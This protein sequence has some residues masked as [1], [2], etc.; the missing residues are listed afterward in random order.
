MHERRTRQVPIANL[1]IDEGPRPLDQE[2]V[3]ALA[4]S[5]ATFGLHTPI[6]ADVTAG[7]DGFVSP[8]PDKVLYRIITGRHR[9][10]AAKQLGWSTIET[11]SFVENEFFTKLMDEE[12][13]FNEADYDVA[14]EMWAIAENLHRAE[15]NALQ[16]A[17]QI[18]RWIELEE[19]WRASSKVQS[20]RVAPIESKREDGRGHRPEGGINAASRELGIERTEAQRSVKIAGL[21]DEAKIAAR[22]AGFD[23]NQK[24][25]LGA[26]KAAEAGDSDIVFLRREHARRE[27]EKARKEAEGINR[28][29][30]RVI[31]LTEAD[32][33]A[34]WIMARTDLNELPQIISWF[35]GVKSKDVIAALR[36]QAA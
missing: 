4:K 5:M 6:F 32:R 33:F 21:S 31:A 25:L 1:V 13:D 9:V 18:A 24:V 27:A 28:D 8:D 2:R 19:K 20:A 12:G 29:T 15:L 22:E 34:E 30:N 23:D 3:D 7:P 26:A 16:R 11:M 10:A 35:D 17:E 36:R 14:A